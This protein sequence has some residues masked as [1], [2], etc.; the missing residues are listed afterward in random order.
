M[1][2]HIGKMNRYMTRTLYFALL[3]YLP[4]TLLIQCS[5]YFRGLMEFM[6]R[7]NTFVDP[8]NNRSYKSFLPYGQSVSAKRNNA[9]SPGTLSLERHRLLWL[10]L[11]HRTDFFIQKYKVLHIAPEQCFHKVFK[12]RSNLQYITA[13]LESPIADLHFDLHEI[14]LEDDTFDVVICNH[15]LE[16][17]AD[18]IQCMKELYR[19]MK[20]GGWGILQVPI[21]MSRTTTLEDAAYDTP[22]LRELHYWQKD[23]LRLYGLDYPSRL[24]QAG[25]QVEVIDYAASICEESRQQMQIN[26]TEQI[27]LCRK[28]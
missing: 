26:G 5:Y 25:F 19:V 27:Y 1:I 20:P 17:V 2:S 3:R 9:L 21:D 24:A 15:V 7:G 4:R 10:F 28:V 22:E 12:N 16:H 6:L 8:I 23:H 18:D 11:H 13:D 14:P